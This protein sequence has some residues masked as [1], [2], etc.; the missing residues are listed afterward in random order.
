MLS[1]DAR[2]APRVGAGGP[3]PGW[4]ALALAL[5]CGGADRPPRWPTDGSLTVA[6]AS[7][8]ITLDPRVGTDSGS[9]RVYQLLVNGLVTRTPEGAL[10][11]DLAE[12]WE[13][14]DEGRRWRFHLRPGVR[15]HDG[16]A[17]SSADVVWT[18]A[19]LVDGTVATTK[20]AA[21]EIVERVEA[22]GPLTVDF[23]L[24]EPFG[25]FLAEL[26]PAQG[27]V[28]AGVGAEQMNRSPVGTGPFRLVSRSADRVVL[29]PFAGHFRGAPQLSQLVL[30][31]VPDDTVRALEL[32]KGS[33]Q[34]VVN[35]LAADV[36]PMFR[37]RRGYQVVES[38]S[39]IFA[40]LGFNLRDP[41]LAD[42]RVRRAIAHAIDRERLVRTVWR[43]L[44]LVS[45]SMFAPGN[46]ARHPDLPPLRHDP[47]AARRL[48][49]AAGYRDPDG[50]GP[51]PR[52]RLVF[53]TSTSEP[54]LLQAQAIQAMLAQVGIA[55]EIRSH[56]FATF[57]DDIRHGRF[58]VFS[59]TRAGALDPHL[60]RLILHSRSVPPAGQNRGFYLNPE[61]DALIDAGA[62]EVDPARRLPYY[63]RAQ[64]LFARDLPYVLLFLRTNF[65]VLPEDVVGYQ[66]Y[67]GGELLSLRTARWR[68]APPERLAATA[69][70]PATGTAR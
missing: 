60:F 66:N 42:R 39:S 36:V 52:L 37:R 41:A 24:R 55:V 4:L 61:L 22:A 20:R 12:R 53:K 63:L 23:V 44:G 67:P 57:Y 29:A 16:R 47:A 18:F 58:Q 31:E 48:L 45:E 34:L 14:L 13:T 33:V 17:L 56:E 46:W 50:P 7:A 40:Y 43:G 30:R 62:R 27:I 26:T 10:V 35:D 38:P 64:E 1:D 6:L 3:L 28:P 32:M 70:A 51:R 19:G 21:F 49:D 8:P 9:Q 59:L 54:F 69:A 15:F 5:G 25:A 65:A 68:S 2:A 11:P